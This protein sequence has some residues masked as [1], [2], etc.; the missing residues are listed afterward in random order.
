VNVRTTYHLL[1]FG[2]FPIG[3]MGLAHLG[4]IHPAFAFVPVPYVVLVVLLA[5]RIRCPKCSHRLMMQTFAILGHRWQTDSPYVRR[6][7]DS[8]GYDLTGRGGEPPPGGPEAGEKAM[9]PVPLINPSMPVLF[10]AIAI[11]GLVGGGMQLLL[12]LTGLGKWFL[13]PPLRES[14]LAGPLVG[15][16][17]ALAISLALAILKRYRQGLVLYFV[18]V[19]YA[20]GL[21]VYDLWQADMELWQAAMPGRTSTIVTCACFTIFLLVYG[22]VNRGWF[23]SEEK[24]RG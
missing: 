13:L 10:R 5:R 19:A 7:C 9:P 24:D 16:N 17:G 14:P 18:F 23:R 3:A 4:L 1:I 20:F 12:A 15:L 2:A 8:C 6:Y 22:Y 11:L 21:V